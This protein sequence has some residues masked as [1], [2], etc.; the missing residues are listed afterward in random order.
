MIFFYNV[1]MC[2]L[3]Y[4]FAHV[5]MCHVSNLSTYWCSTRDKYEII[6]I[7]LL[8]GSCASDDRKRHGRERNTVQR[9]NMN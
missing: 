8:N 3:K 6:Q 9:G 2:V 1:C 4:I 7:K 5:Y